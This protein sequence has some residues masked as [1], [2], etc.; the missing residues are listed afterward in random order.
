MAVDGNIDHWYKIGL[1]KNNKN[2]T[3]YVWGGLLSIAHAEKSGKL[4]IAGIK[5]YNSENGFVGEC[6]LVE[7]GKILS[8]VEFKPHYL[9]DGVNEGFYSY[10]V[11]GELTGG[12]GLKG[13]ERIFKI[14]TNYEACGY[15]R[16][17][18]FIGEGKGRLYFIGRDTSVSEAGVFHVEEK[19]IFPA[20]KKGAEDMVILV[21]ESFEFDEAVNDYKLREKKETKY[22]WKDYRLNPLK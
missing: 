10:S 14:F 1:K 7:N 15:P 8:A 5:S 6:R 13:I 3:G 18:V 11:S 16:G 12:K 4:F 20:D 21:N 22:K 2:I 9:P 19:F 17:N